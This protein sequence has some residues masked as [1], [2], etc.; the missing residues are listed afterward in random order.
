MDR[1]FTDVDGAAAL[2]NDPHWWAEPR[3]GDVRRFLEYVDTAPDIAQAQALAEALDTKTRE[4]HGVPAWVYAES[5]RAD[6][7]RP[8]APTP[9]ALTAY[10][11]VTVQGVQDAEARLS[12]L[13]VNPSSVA[14]GQNPD[15]SDETRRTLAAEGAAATLR[16]HDQLAETPQLTDE[17]MLRLTWDLEAHPWDSGPLRTEAQTN[18]RTHIADRSEGLALPSTE[19]MA[20]VLNHHAPEAARGAST[21]AGQIARATSREALKSTV[22][23]GSVSRAPG[24]SVRPE[25]PQMRGAERYAGSRNVATVAPARGLER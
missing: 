21:V 10:E 20:T 13:G 12:E 2:V 15:I 7:P 22:D 9:G 3:H 23:A 24:V 6:A 8:P 14:Y 25:A 11:T 4:H 19:R 17:A 1:T 18:L 5:F 16:V